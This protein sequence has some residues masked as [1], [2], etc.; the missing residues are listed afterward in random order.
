M[1]NLKE[2]VVDMGI[3]ILFQDGSSMVLSEAYLA[4]SL[5]VVIAVSLLT[6][7]CIYRYLI[8]KKEIISLTTSLN[9]L[10]EDLADSNKKLKEVTEQYIET[11]KELSDLKVVYEKQN[12]D[13]AELLL[14]K[15]KI[16]SENRE[17]SKRVISLQKGWFD[18]QSIFVAHLIGDK[19]RIAAEIRRS[20]DIDDSTKLAAVNGIFDDLDA[21]A[22]NNEE[23]LN[24]IFNTCEF[25]SGAKE[26]K[27]LI[28]TINTQSKKDETVVIDSDDEQNENSSEVKED[29]SLN[30][31]VSTN[32]ETESIDTDTK[33]N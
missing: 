15:S 3:K 25:A 21:L 17:L 12:E 13:I 28:D 11:D 20:T 7:Y 33:S 24:K 1:Q 22:L 9:N 6:I 19:L 29:D 30:E 2:P 8:S 27:K 26:V 18:Y 10:N 4:L 14:E 32:Q 23:S 5:L 16:L 31:E